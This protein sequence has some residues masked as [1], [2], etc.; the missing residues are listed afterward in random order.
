MADDDW[1]GNDGFSR[2]GIRVL[3]DHSWK[4]AYGLELIRINKEADMVTE[5]TGKFYQPYYP[6]EAEFREARSV[7]RG[8][9]RATL[10]VRNPVFLAGKQRRK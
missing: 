7:L 3:I 5:L 4:A 8:R 1:A 9:K 10:R 6:T 2:H